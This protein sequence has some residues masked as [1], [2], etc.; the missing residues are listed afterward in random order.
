MRGCVIQRGKKF[1]FIVDGP[2]DPKTGKRKQIWVST[3]CTKRRDAER[4]CRQYIAN[5]E[6]AAKEEEE[7]KAKAEAQTQK[8]DITLGEFLGRHYVD[9]EGPVTEVGWLQHA[10]TTTARTTYRGYESIV[11]C[12]LIPKLGH[13]RL[14]DLTTQMIDQYYANALKD[15]RVGKGKGALSPQTVRNHHAVL[16]SALNRAVAYQYIDHNPAK[17]AAPPSLKNAIETNTTKP[18]RQPAKKMNILSPEQVNTLLQT[19]RDARIFLAVAIA[20]MTGMRRGEVLALRWCDIDFEAKTITVMRNLQRSIDGDLIPD[21]PKTKSSIRQIDIPD[22]LVNEL[23][24]HREAAREECEMLA[25]EFD[26]E[27]LITHRVDGKPLQPD[28][29]TREFKQLLRR[30]GL[31]DVTF[32]DLRHTHATTL[33]RAGVPIKVVSERLGHSSVRVTMEIY[34]HVLPTQQKEAAAKL[35]LLYKLY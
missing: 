22:L 13:I 1:Y 20:T 2:R 28:N 32:H 18:K 23:K 11:R 6:N 30:A 29:V 26:E 35:D 4:A 16:R 21:T 27:A 7:Q 8:A 34:W 3:E 17:N 33:I 12:H 25:I 14:R 9:S 15:G 19:A 10:R 31:P 5:M 24:R